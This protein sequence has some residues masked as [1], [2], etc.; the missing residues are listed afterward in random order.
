MQ[1][2]YVTCLCVALLGCVMGANVRCGQTGG[3]SGTCNKVIKGYMYSAPKKSCFSMVLR[4]CATQ[5]KFF[6]TKSDCEECLTF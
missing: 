4:G 6:D 3:V 2:L 5:G 1:I